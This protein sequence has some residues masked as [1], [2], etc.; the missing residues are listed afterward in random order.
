MTSE[1]FDLDRVLWLVSESRL[2][3]DIL[4]RGYAVVAADK[5]VCQRQLLARNYNCGIIHLKLDNV[6]F[7]IGIQLLGG[8]HIGNGAYCHTVEPADDDLREVLVAEADRGRQDV[9]END[10][11]G[12]VGGRFV[13]EVAK[14]MV[15]MR[16]V[17]KN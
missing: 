9:T 13:G 16:R 10:D 17:P 6:I 7:R 15:E 8:E 12:A 11:V 4:Q 1:P 3:V 14:V 2:R 5:L